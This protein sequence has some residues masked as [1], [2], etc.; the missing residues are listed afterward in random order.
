MASKPRFIDPNTIHHVYNRGSQKMSLFRSTSD[1]HRFLS[2]ATEYLDKHAIEIIAYCLMPN[3][4]HFLVREL[5]LGGPIPLGSSIAGYFHRLLTSYAKY[6][7][8]KHPDYTGGVF[9]GKYKN[10]I[11]QSDNYFFQLI[12]YIHDNPVK[13]GLVERP[14][15]WPYSSYRGLI[16]LHY[17]PLITHSPFW[18]YLKHRQIYA[19][20]RR[21]QFDLD[22]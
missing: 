1:Y 19:D 13:S 22:L 20:F 16:K 4:F 14:E 17:D 10:K 5:D 9:Q 11:V 2:R 8:H 7:S 15:Q 6:F 21:H 18:K 12:G 3:H